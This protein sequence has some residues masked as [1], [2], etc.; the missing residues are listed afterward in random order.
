VEEDL[1]QVVLNPTQFKLLREEELTLVAA[2][3]RVKLVMDGI[4]AAANIE[5]PVEV[6]KYDEAT[7]IFY[8]R[9]SGPVAEG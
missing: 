4:L 2:Q 1:I 5:G 7:R 6:V 3:G 8:L 9:P